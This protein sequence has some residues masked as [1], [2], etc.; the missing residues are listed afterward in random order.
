MSSLDIYL[1][2]DILINMDIEYEDILFKLPFYAPD[3]IKFILGV[4][5]V[6]SA[7]SSWL[8]LYP[9]GKSVRFVSET[10]IG[11]I[12][13]RQNFLR[14][15]N[16]PELK[17]AI[18]MAYFRVFR[19]LGLSEE[20]FEACYL[21]NLDTRD[22]FVAERSLGRVI[23]YENYTGAN[24][25]EYLDYMTFL[26]MWGIDN[27]K[28]K[29]ESYEDSFMEYMM[30]RQIQGRRQLSA[31]RDNVPFADYSYEAYVRIL[32][33]GRGVYDPLQREELMR[34]K[35]EDLEV[36]YEEVMSMWNVSWYL[37]RVA[38]R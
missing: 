1:L 24:V 35:A 18:N 22:W 26:R 16:I 11:T 20:K 7:P 30:E 13:F 9:Y 29:W 14:L 36:D 27:E 6:D 3:N 15:V 10:C 5:I 28:L 31:Y 37:E 32:S 21:I 33:A 23:V 34:A 17:P 12:L 2:K 19:S 38:C 25:K 4:D 8:M